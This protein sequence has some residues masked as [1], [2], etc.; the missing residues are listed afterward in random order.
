MVPLILFLTSSTM[1]CG[2]WGT[3]GIEHLG[4]KA[5]AA[6]AKSNLKYDVNSVRVPTV[7]RE[8]F[9][10]VPASIASAG[11]I[12]SILSASGLSSRSRNCLEYGEK[13]ST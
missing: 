12:P 4:Q 1:F 6:L 13:V 10:T 2:S 3:T 11:G 5:I 8:L 7:D 9:T